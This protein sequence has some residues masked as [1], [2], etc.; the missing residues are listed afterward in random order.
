M[1][2]RA[3]PSPAL[4]RF[5]SRDRPVM[6]QGQP[7]PATQTAAAEI[8][9]VGCVERL[10]I[11]GYNCSIQSATLAACH[12]FSSATD[13]EE[14]IFDPARFFVISPEVI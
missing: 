10:S 13:W 11:S 14:A 8:C 2:G 4:R 5:V 1:T 7:L 3:G 6:L 12:T 9:L